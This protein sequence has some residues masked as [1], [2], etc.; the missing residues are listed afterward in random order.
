MG[1]RSKLWSSPASE[2]LPAWNASRSISIPTMG[3]FSAE[4]AGARFKDCVKNGVNHLFHS[5]WTFVTG[6][7]GEAF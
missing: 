6:L 3:H 4:S 7:F 1:N 5:G 2:T